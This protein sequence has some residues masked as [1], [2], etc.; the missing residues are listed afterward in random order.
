MNKSTRA[1][2][3]TKSK[4]ASNKSKGST[5]KDNGD[6]S[7]KHIYGILDKGKNTKSR[8]LIKVNKNSEKKISLQNLIKIEDEEINYKKN[9]MGGIGTSYLAQ[10]AYGVQRNKRL[11]AKARSPRTTNMMNNS[12]RSFRKS[13]SSKKNQKFSNKNSLSQRNNNKSKNSIGV[14][15]KKKRSNMNSYGNTGSR[16]Q[17]TS[18]GKKILSSYDQRVN[19]K[20]PGKQPSGWKSSLPIPKVK[21]KSKASVY[22]PDSPPKDN[23]SIQ[24]KSRKKGEN[25]IDRV[26]KEIKISNSIKNIRITPKSKKTGTNASGEEFE[27]NS[28]TTDQNELSITYGARSEISVKKS[29]MTVIIESQIRTNKNQEY[30]IKYLLDE[31]EQLVEMV[32]K[33]KKELDTFKEEVRRVKT[34][35]HYYPDN[36]ELIVEESDK[37]YSSE[38]SEEGEKKVMIASSQELKIDPLR[39]SSNGVNPLRQTIDP[40]RGSRVPLSNSIDPLRNSMPMNGSF[41][42]LRSTNFST[43]NIDPLRS[44]NYSSP[45]LTAKADSVYTTTKVTDNEKIKEFQNL[46]ETFI[47]HLKKRNNEEDTKF[48]EFTFGKI[49]G[50]INNLNNELSNTNEK[51]MNLLL[52]IT[53]LKRRTFSSEK[54]IT[55]EEGEKLIKEHKEGKLDQSEVIGFHDDWE[56]IDHKSEMQMIDSKNNKI[57]IPGNLIKFGI[58][59]KPI[60][61]LTEIETKGPEMVNKEGVWETKSTKSAKDKEKKLSLNSQDLFEFKNGTF[62]FNLEKNNKLRNKKKLKNFKLSKNSSAEEL[63]LSN[64]VQVKG[65]TL[66]SKVETEEKIEFDSKNSDRILEKIHSVTNHTKLNRSKN[67]KY[68]F[69]SNVK[70]SK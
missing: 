38:S 24:S 63:P 62:T 9:K 20:S 56:T 2:S 34:L 60:N 48:A 44:T 69:M 14:V 40:L 3:R 54:K 18:P 6:L 7:D 13:E 61:K 68:F 46:S 23:K 51:N 27:L 47:N 17:Y 8:D 64:I 10:N 59:D 49:E 26:K 37:G 21:R 16:K 5:R 19:Y 66:N 25:A 29:A 42:P 22:N 45:P 70:N 58:L 32:D 30:L 53:D 1:K 11:S 12:K 35:S 28:E 55:K 52:V 50:I 33:Q 36:N 41:D 31:R 67:F 15:K 39:S 57:T 65:E 43:P 4:R